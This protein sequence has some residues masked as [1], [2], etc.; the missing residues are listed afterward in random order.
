MT[1]LNMNS[2][3]ELDLKLFYNEAV[4]YADGKVRKQGEKVLQ[5]CVTKEL[6]FKEFIGNF[7]SN[8]KRII[9]DVSKR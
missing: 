5:T 6:L 9:T 7:K 3:Q 8:A 4:A 1:I 2:Q